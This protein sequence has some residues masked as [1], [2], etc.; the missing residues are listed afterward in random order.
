MHPC[1]TLQASRIKNSHA[2]SPEYALSMRTIASALIFLLGAAVPALAQG[3]WFQ[4]AVLERADVKK[5]L[6]SVDE[7][8][9]A[10]VGEWIRLVEMPAP[11]R[12][13]QAR[14]EYVRAE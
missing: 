5:A 7:R 2:R 8:S 1:R 4:P 10:I 13:E 9:S 12:K 6:Q 3:N 11:S 14:A